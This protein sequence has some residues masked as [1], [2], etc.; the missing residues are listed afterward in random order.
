MIT[1]GHIFRDNLVSINLINNVSNFNANLKM[2]IPIQRYL[3]AQ[4]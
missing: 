2:P 3:C 4:M 1:V